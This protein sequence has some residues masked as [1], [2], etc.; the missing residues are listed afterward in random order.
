MDIEQVERQLLIAG[1]E[2]DF[3][4]ILEEK[5]QEYQ[6]PDWW[7]IGLGIQEAGSPEEEFKAKDIYK[8]FLRF[9]TTGMD[10]EQRVQAFTQ[11]RINGAAR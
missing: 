1:Y 7:R 3:L 11:S 8:S 4:E 2:A 5:A 9:K 6:P 10:F